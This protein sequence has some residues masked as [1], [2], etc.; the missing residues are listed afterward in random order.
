MPEEQIANYYI[1]LGMGNKFSENVTNLNYK[2]KELQS[3]FK[4]LAIIRKS[5]AESRSKIYE[6]LISM[7]LNLDKFK[8]IL[9]N[10]EFKKLNDSLKAI[11]KYQKLKTVKKSKKVKKIA[12]K[13]KVVFKPQ[14]SKIISQEDEIRKNALDSEKRELDLLKK[15]LEKLSEQLKNQ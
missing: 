5:S 9:P 3:V 12:K 15:D 4:N 10:E 6:N 7:R 14:A 2:N 1:K 11:E 8:N 13:E